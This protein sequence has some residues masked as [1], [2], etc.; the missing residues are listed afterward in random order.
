ML[1]HRQKIGFKP[2]AVAVTAY[3]GSSDLSS[4]R[5]GAHQH[6][7]DQGSNGQGTLDES[8]P[9]TPAVTHAVAASGSPVWNHCMSCEF[10]EGQLQA[11]L[12][13]LALVHETDGS[14]MARYSS[15][16]IL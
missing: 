16:Y 4:S 3:V 1:P 10:E 12:L 15:S 6:A 7:D 14:I 5:S 13:H 2:A 8:T 9:K 11:G